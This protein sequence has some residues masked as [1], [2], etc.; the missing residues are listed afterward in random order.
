[1]VR[2]HSWIRERNQVAALWVLALAALLVSLVLGR[3]RPPGGW[4]SLEFPA[5]AGPE[6]EAP[7]S[8]SAGEREVA[9]FGLGLDFLFA[10]LYPLFLSLLLGR[11][12][13]RWTLPGWLRRT[14]S[15]FS[16]L[17]LTACPL[18]AAENVGLYLL[19][20]G[21]SAAGLGWA[22]TVVSAAKWLV[23]LAALPVAV[24]CLGARVLGRRPETP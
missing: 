15:F 7:E 2:P 1:M 19:I 11:A 13:E 12:A 10:V 3:H 5:L 9:L 16:G 24:L 21:S 6:W 18:D 22:V 23:A 17:V 14:S 8:W 20:M 4:L